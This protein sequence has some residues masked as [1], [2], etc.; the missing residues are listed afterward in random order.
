MRILFDECIPR[1][2]K[3]QFPEHD[4]VTVPEAGFAGRKN[5]ELLALAEQHAIQVFLTMDKGLQSQQ[6]LG[7]RESALLLIRAS[8]NRLADLLPHVA[9]C[10]VALLSITPGR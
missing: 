6:S 8:S 3:L 5:G 2:F 4:C 9:A 7:K 10:R 1:K